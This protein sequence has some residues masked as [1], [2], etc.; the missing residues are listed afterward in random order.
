MDKEDYPAPNNTP[1]TGP[2]SSFTEFF[3][4]K[5]L[6]KAEVYYSFTAAFNT[7]LA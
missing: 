2:I 4:A 1:S 6:A 5:A 7:E 3:I